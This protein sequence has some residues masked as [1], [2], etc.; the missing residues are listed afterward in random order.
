MSRLDGKSL[1]KITTKEVPSGTING[2]NVTFTLA[3]IPQENE[4][5]QLYLDGLFLVEGVDY[6]LSSVTIT[7][8]T[9]PALGQ[10]LRAAY[11][12]NTGE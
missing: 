2:S 12:R 10:S 5:V 6:S 8:T 7:M 9:A 1:K 3:N 11:W 4:A